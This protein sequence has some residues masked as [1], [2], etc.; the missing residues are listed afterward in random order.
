MISPDGQSDDWPT[1]SDQRMLTLP[2]V[3]ALD[4]RTRTGDPIQ[5]LGDK[6]SRKSGNLIAY[7]HAQLRGLVFHPDDGSEDI[8]FVPKNAK[9][10]PEGYPGILLASLDLAARTAD[11]TK[12]SWLRHPLMALPE[13]R[14]DYGREIQSVLDSWRG[15]FFYIQEDQQQNI[16]GLRSPQ[17]GALHAISAH[18]AVSDSPATIVMPTG[19]GK[20][21][22]MLS[23][24]LSVRCPKLLVIVPTDAL[25]TQIAEKFISLG[26]LK[27]SNSGVLDHRARYPIVCTLLHIPRSI[28]ELDDIFVRAQVIVTTSHIAGRCVDEIQSRMAFHCPYLFID[29]AHHAEAPTWS[30]FKQ[31]FQ[32][33]RIVQFTATPFR[34]DG[35]PLDG[36]IVFK[37]PL[38]RAQEEG[39]F[40]PIR[41]EPVMAFNRKRSD[42]AIA[43]KA[44]E[45]LRAEAH[46]GHIL[47]AR[48]ESIARSKEVFPLYEELAEFSPVE[49]NTEI[50]SS[51]ERERIRNR[52]ISGE[53]RIVVC[54]DMLGEGFDLPELKIA[55]FH[56]I[57][58]TLAVTLQ[59]AGRFTRARPDLGN[60][61]FIANTASVDVRD[62]LQ[63]LYTRDP[64]WNLLLPQLSDTAINEQVSLQSFLRGFTNFVDEIPL[65]TVTPATSAVVYQTAC[66]DWNPSNF[67]AGIPGIESCEQVHSAINNNEHTLVVVTARRVPLPWTD[68]E[69][70]FSWDWELYV[71]IWVS[72]Q[73][74]LFINSSTNAGEY[75][76]LAKAVAGER[77]ALISGNN[78]FRSFANVKRLHLQNVGLTELLGRNVRYTGRMGADVGSEVTGAQRQR[79]VKSVLA[80][81]G[82]EDGEDTT[83]AASKKGR[84]WSRRR[85]RLDQLISWCKKVGNKLLDETVD[86]E[87][88]LKGTLISR[89]ITTRPKKMPFFADWPDEIYKLTE[90]RWEISI[91]GIK[92]PLNDA[93]ILLRSPVID[94]PLLLEIATEPIRVGIELELFEAADIPSYAFRQID[95]P[96]I[97]I[98][99]GDRAEP[100]SIVDFFYENP[101]AIWFVDGSYLEGN[102]YVELPTLRSSFDQSKIQE[103]DWNG[104]NIRKEAQ[105]EGRDPDSIQARVIRQLRNQGHHIIMDDNDKGESA[106]VVAIQVAGTLESPTKIEV[107]F[108]HCKYSQEAEPG[109]RV[110]DLYEVCGQAQKSLCWLFSSQRRTDLF[111]HLL[112][113]EELRRESG[114]ATRYETGNDE[115]L[116]TV[117]EISKLCGVAF[118][119][120]I[121]QPGL[122]KARVSPE[123]LALLGVTEN[124]L[125]EVRKVPLGVIA[126]A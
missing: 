13:R 66:D 18:W 69:T 76:S 17:L 42:R 37:Y 95:G 67:R 102:Q 23:I 71:V 112:R 118:K 39:Y 35:K 111:T 61:T 44:I 104:I 26:I 1:Q 91:D 4:E 96:S 97:E 123:Q 29:E 43:R 38:K 114:R 41:F 92:Y 36:E 33:C 88:V 31:K 110:E 32:S 5:Q 24:L 89:T 122:S 65:K 47:M 82:Y 68:V 103:W 28:G 64:D 83:I 57:R 63:K 74:L 100:E 119:I 20:T 12:A 70:L 105:G 93:D 79:T 2:R 107:E 72:D 6:P 109:R 85:E 108:Y 3:F 124:H 90:A 62:E 60:A 121:V 52:I 77:A 9:R 49:L 86:P 98:S 113:R 25:R 53:S 56:D 59:L 126:S 51:S 19:T 30:A 10:L 106:D 99:R 11:L 21:E 117:R 54:V 116:Q 78:V 8:L 125:M 48:V 45:I 115:L 40:K 14:I 80:G 55:A 50:K 7:Q 34:E 58:K 27:S 84:I 81:T 16:A 87:E 101:P 120:F 15:S 22:T 75:K 46:L 94:G 73:K